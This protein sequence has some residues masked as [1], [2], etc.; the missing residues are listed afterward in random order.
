MPDARCDLCERTLRKNLWRE[1][2]GINVCHM[3]YEDCGGN[4]FRVNAAFMQKEY[5]EFDGERLE[6]EEK[7]DTEGVEP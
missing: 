1:C 3:C 7:G 2:A 6:D 4:A 5:G